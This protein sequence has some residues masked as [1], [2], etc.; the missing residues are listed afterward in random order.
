[1]P[2]HMVSANIPP[3]TPMTRPA[4]GLTPIQPASPR[5]SARPS[6]N[7]SGAS[8][9]NHET[10]RWNSGESSPCSAMRWCAVGVMSSARLT[11]STD[12][13]PSFKSCA[14]RGRCSKPGSKAARKSKPM[15][16]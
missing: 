4:T 9:P 13:D 6:A 12:S 1:M 2:Y 5:S 3:T 10:K 15:S 14:R 11:H 7:G 8:E 16:T